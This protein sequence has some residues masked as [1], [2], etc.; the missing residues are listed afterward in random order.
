MASSSAPKPW[1]SFVRPLLI[2]VVLSPN[3]PSSVINPPQF[4]LLMTPSSNAK[5]KPWPCSTTG[6]V[7][8]KLK[9]NSGFFGAPGAHN[10]ADYS[11]RNH[12]PPFNMR[13]IGLTMRGDHTIFVLCKGVY[14]HAD[15]NH[16][17]LGPTISRTKCLWDQYQFTYIADQPSLV[18]N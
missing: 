1:S 3:I 18:I 5:P 16:L 12:P 15:Y 9:V 2:W 8:V 7:A 13:P 10:H 14:I 6:S 11:T 17:P 4:W